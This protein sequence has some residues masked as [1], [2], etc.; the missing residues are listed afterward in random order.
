MCASK[1][2]AGTLAILLVQVSCQI[3]KQ[4]GSNKQQ[5]F[6]Q[7]DESR[8][9]LLGNSGASNCWTR[10][11]KVAFGDLQNG[12]VYRSDFLHYRKLYVS[13]LCID[14]RF[15]HQA[16]FSFQCRKAHDQESYVC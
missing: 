14:L 11:I 9:L 16:V 3:L 1:M 13:N 15:G 6:T 2:H 10:Q 4:D 8:C 12:T 7:C 5:Y